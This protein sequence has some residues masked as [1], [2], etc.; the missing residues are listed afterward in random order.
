M[1]IEGYSPERKKVYCSNCKNFSAR[2][3]NSP[4]NNKYEHT[5]LRRRVIKTHIKTP[6]QLNKRNNCRFYEP[7]RPD[8]I[9]SPPPLRVGE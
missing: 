7:K 8:N 6:R 3:C 1:G 9:P 2:E 4:E 5:W